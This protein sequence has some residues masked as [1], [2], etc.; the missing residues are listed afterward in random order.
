[1]NDIVTVSHDP[2]D[3]VTNPMLLFLLQL[4]EMYRLE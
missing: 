2:D 4:R 1:M 3:I